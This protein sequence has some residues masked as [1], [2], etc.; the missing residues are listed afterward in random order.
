MNFNNARS[1]NSG[2]QYILFCWLVIWLTQSVQIIQKA[3]KKLQ[4][5]INIWQLVL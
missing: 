2:S 1:F 5:T 3:V 4:V